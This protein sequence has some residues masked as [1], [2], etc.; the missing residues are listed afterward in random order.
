[1]PQ[2][3][4]GSNLFVPIRI[5]FLNQRPT[6]LQAPFASRTETSGC[7]AGYEYAM[8]T[9]LVWHGAALERLKRAAGEEVLV[10]LQLQCDGQQ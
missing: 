5:M 2:A 10:S 9:Q 7:K 6:A 1:M 3:C 8:K 4:A